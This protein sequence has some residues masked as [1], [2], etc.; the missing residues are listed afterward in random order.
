MTLITPKHFVAT[1]ILGSR[2]RQGL[3]KVWAKSEFEGHISCSWECKRV[4]GN[5]PPNSQMN[6]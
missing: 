4:G 1:L 6:S 2:P 5:E 3:A